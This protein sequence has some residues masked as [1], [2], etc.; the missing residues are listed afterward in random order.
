M[1][2]R[3]FNS[4]YDGLGVGHLG[5]RL[6]RPAYPPRRVWHLASTRSASRAL[7]RCPRRGAT[8]PRTSA[9]VGK[10]V[11]GEGVGGRD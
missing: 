1:F 6:W 4:N 7:Q 11:G 2:L 8:P 3:L 9:K 5:P 10:E